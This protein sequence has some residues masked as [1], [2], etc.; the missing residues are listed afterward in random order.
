MSKQKI[1]IGNSVEKRAGGRAAAK[2]SEP[3]KVYFSD[4]RVRLGSSLALKLKRVMKAAGFEALIP[5]FDDSAWSDFGEQKV[6]ASRE[7]GSV[8]AA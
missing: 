7:D 2:K 1:S 8:A 6:L 3:S 5:R 4:L